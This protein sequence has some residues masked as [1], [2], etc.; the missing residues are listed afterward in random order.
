[1]VAYCLKKVSFSRWQ[2][3]VFPE[4]MQE[5]ELDSAVFKIVYRIESMTKNDLAIWMLWAYIMFFYLSILKSSDLCVSEVLVFTPLFE[6]ASKQKHGVKSL[7]LFYI[8][9][10]KRKVNNYQQ[11]LETESSIYS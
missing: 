3:I 9:V 5:V 4:T 11:V 7:E 6:A 8:I 2:Q 1:M 10:A